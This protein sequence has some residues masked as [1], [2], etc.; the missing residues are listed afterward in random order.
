MM[1]LELQ[2]KRSTQPVQYTPFLTCYI[3]DWVISLKIIRVSIAYPSLTKFH[4]TWASAFWATLNFLI[5]STKGLY[6]WCTFK[7]NP[8]VASTTRSA[9]KISSF[10]WSYTSCRDNYRPF[11]KA[12]QWKSLPGAG[13]KITPSRQSPKAGNITCREKAY[14]TIRSHKCYNP[15][16]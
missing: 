2:A 12:S 10:C 1:R 6:G 3:H 13:R 11:I 5:A 15:I 8:R 9:S 4:A 16:C 7:S 14:T